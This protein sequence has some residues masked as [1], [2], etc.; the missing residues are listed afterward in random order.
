MDVLREDLLQ[1]R[2]VALG[3]SVPDG[4]AAALGE[5]GARVERMDELG[6]PDDD[7]AGDWARAHAPLDVLVYDGW[8]SFGDGGGR[9]VAA[10][11]Q[12]AWRTIREV[13]VGAL[14][15]SQQPAKIVLLGPPPS[16]GSYADAVAAALENLARTLSVEWARYAVTVVMVARGEA[17][18]EQEL[19]ELVCF[20][21]S[22]GGEYFSGCR[23]DLG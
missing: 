12:D 22:P 6:E 5:L 16:A 8:P 13:A 23:L 19:A 7:Q 3:S 15:G 18:G 14:I 1:G 17:A 4:I 9:A 2:S 21:A 11:M 20:L 10:A